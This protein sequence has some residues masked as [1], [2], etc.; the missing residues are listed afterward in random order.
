M[1]YVVVVPNS[2]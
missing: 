2:Y 1:T